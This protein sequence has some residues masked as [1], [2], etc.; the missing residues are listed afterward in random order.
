MTMD[1][2][3]MLLEKSLT[4]T[5]EWLYMVTREGFWSHQDITS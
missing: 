4:E 1:F 5:I 3:Q 2:M